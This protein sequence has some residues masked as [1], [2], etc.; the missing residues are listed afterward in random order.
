MKRLKDEDITKAAQAFGLE[1]CVI[2]AIVDVESSGSGFLPDGRP[3]ILFEGHIF[4]KELKKK[5]I[6][7][8]PLQAANSDILYPKWDKSHYKGGAAEWG[9]LERAKTINEE[10]ALSSAS[11]GL[12]QIM[13]F[14]YKACGFSS[15]ASFVKAQSESE[16]EQLKSFCNFIKSEGLIPLLKS[17]DWAAFA[18]RYNGPGYAQ[19]KYDTKLQAAYDKCAG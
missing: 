10:A 17:Q 19:N 12:F 4:W 1:P 8:A 18:K 14:N 15:V 5:G 16:F 13:G 7:P 2:Q 9:R 11:Y 3:K 6:E